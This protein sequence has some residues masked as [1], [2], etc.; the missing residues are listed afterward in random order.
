[1]IYSQWEKID[2]ARYYRRLGSWPI[3][4]PLRCMKD[5][6]AHSKAVKRTWKVEINV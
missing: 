4:G 2:L 3:K 5:D 1:M 6:T